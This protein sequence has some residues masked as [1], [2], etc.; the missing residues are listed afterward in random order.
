MLRLPGCPVCLAAE[1]AGSRAVAVAGCAPGP[2]LYFSSRSRERTGSIRSRGFRKKYSRVQLSWYRV[3][4]G[5]ACSRTVVRRQREQ[6]ELKEQAVLE[7]ASKRA[8]CGRRLLCLKRRQSVQVFSRLLLERLQLSSLLAASKASSQQG[9]SAR[10]REAS[11]QVAVC[12]AVDYATSP[13]TL[14]WSC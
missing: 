2:T 10:P 1:V 6:S 5:S 12:L 8:P 9:S 14:S 4:S 7:Q 11:S 13:W 3:V